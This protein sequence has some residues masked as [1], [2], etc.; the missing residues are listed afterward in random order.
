MTQNNTETEQ[1]EL[2]TGVT[3]DTSSRTTEPVE[4]GEPEPITEIAE[5]TGLNEDRI[6]AAIDA[7]QPDRQED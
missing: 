6:Q 4:T 7:Y 2:S 5:T 1:D 3:P